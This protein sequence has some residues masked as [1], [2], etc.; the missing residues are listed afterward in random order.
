M[1]L[2]K[3][4]VVHITALLDHV[5]NHMTWKYKS[6]AGHMTYPGQS[7]YF[8]V[9]QSGDVKLQHL[10]IFQNDVGSSSVLLIPYELLVTLDNIAQLVSQVVLNGKRDRCGLI[11]TSE[12]TSCCTWLRAEP[13]MTTAGLTDSGGTGKTVIT[14]Q[15]G[16]EYL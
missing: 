14:V 16:R 1:Y 2:Y 15:S 10:D 13:C 9:H 4:H 7:G 3:S 12:T 6:H 8:I 11:G 5:L